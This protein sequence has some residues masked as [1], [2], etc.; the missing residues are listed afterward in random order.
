MSDASAEATEHASERVDILVV[1]DNRNNLLAIEELLADLGLNVLRARSGVEA[2]RC[3]LAQD[4]ALALLDI[5]MPELDG[6][7]TAEIIR[8]RDRSRH[9]PIIF[10]TAY[11]RSDEQISRGYEL[12]AVDFLFKPIVPFVLRAKVAAFVD[13]FRK[14]EEIKR[15]ARLLRDIEKREYER[16]LVEANQRW[17][18]ERLR[19]EMIKERRVAETLARTVTERERAEVALQASN[20]RLELLADLAALTALREAV[21]PDMPDDRDLI[22]PGDRVLL[23]IEDDPAFARIL[24][25]LARERGFRSPS[26]CGSRCSTAGRSSTGSSTTRGRGTS[27]SM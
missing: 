4:F 20:R 16:Q 12:G 22:N 17:E 15:Q 18:A 3:L 23:I 24:L 1:D 19:E 26:T 25:D 2:L 21:A 5:Q 14:T 27:P 10:L 8:S 13:L 9:M 7:Q 6:F 11:G